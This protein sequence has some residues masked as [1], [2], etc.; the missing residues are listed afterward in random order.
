M[1]QTTLLA[2]SCAITLPPAVTTSSQPCIPSD[3]MPVRMTP[4]MALPHI[5]AAE[6]NSGSTAGR[7]KFTSGP[8]FSEMKAWLLRFATVMWRPPGAR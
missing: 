4:R 8:S 1:P 2:S 5:C 7:Q 3:P 6:P